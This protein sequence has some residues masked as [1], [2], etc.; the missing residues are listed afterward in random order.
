MSSS[1]R[2]EV[3]SKVKVRYT[4]DWNMF[5]LKNILEGGKFLQL[6]TSLFPHP[7]SSEFFNTSCAILGR[8]NRQLPKNICEKFPTNS[9]L[10]LFAVINIRQKLP[11]ISLTKAFQSTV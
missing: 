9:P 5:A 7:E 1:S 4:V 11:M 10:E 8:G 3:I 2:R 6:K